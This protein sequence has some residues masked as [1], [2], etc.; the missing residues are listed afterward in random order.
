MG[1]APPNRGKKAAQLIS[2][3]YIALDDRHARVG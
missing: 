1:F 2:G 3:I